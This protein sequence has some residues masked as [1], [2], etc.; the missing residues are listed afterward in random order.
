[1]PNE[2]FCLSC[3]IKTIFK[4]NEDIYIFTPF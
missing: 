4:E 2:E 3:G 1:M